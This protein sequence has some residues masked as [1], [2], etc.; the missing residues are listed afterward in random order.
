MRGQIRI[1]IEGVHAPAIPGSIL[2]G[3]KTGFI[4]LCGDVC[5]AA[6][7][8]AALFAF[9]SAAQKTMRDGGL[10]RLFDS[11]QQVRTIATGV[12]KAIPGK[13]SA[14]D[15]GAE[16]QDGLRPAMFFVQADPVPPAERFKDMALPWG[17]RREAASSA[18]IDSLYSARGAEWRRGVGLQSP[19]S[20]AEISFARRGLFRFFR[21]R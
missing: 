16:K 19:T 15:V 13:D 7:F 4:F 11:P 5:G 21:K 20:G 9:A 17:K 2:Y 18:L 14:P 6:A 10:G 3:Q 1:W 12:P 8:A